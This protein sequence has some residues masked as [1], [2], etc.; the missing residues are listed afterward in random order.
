[1]GVTFYGTV[2]VGY[3]YVNN[4]SYPSG[5][6]Y[7]GAGYTIFGSPFNSHQVS[8]L[9]NNALS[10]S[11]VGIK[12]EEQIGGGFLAIGKLQTEFN[13]IS[14]E[15]ADA[16][17]SLLR[18]SGQRLGSIENRRRQ[19]LR[20]GLQQCCLWRRQPPDLRHANCWPSVLAGA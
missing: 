17:A 15:L 10:V 11:N 5:A 12:I 18:T 20:S 1:M 13:P 3:A 19:P 2:D 4:G 16:C 14:G 6:F 8:T 7:E 9:N